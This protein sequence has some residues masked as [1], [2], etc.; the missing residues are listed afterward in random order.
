MKAPLVV[1]SEGGVFKNKYKYLTS[2][3]G[4]RFFCE[5]AEGLPL[6]SDAELVKTDNIG[7]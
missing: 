3:E 1:F 7:V 4:I 2:Y 6:P 5:S